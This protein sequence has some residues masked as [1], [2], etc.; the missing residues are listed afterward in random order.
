[1]DWAPESPDGARGDNCGH[2]A[3]IS[4]PGVRRGKRFRYPA[5]IMDIRP[6]VN[7]LFGA[8]AARMNGVVLSDALMMPADNG[9][10]IL[11]AG[12]KNL[13][14]MAR[15]LAV[16]S[17]AGSGQRP[18]YNGIIRIES[19]TSVFPPGPGATPD[20]AMTFC[21]PAHSGHL[22]SPRTCDGTST[23]LSME[24]STSFSC[25][26]SKTVCTRVTTLPSPS[27]MVKP[28]RL[29]MWEANAASRAYYHCPRG[30]CLAPSSTHG[31]DECRWKRH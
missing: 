6:T 5:T 14:P 2:P 17:A 7:S 3:V 18:A 13:E 24:T 22:P 21:W 29:S 28:T 25:L 31:A 9:P 10:H 30:R 27:L 26:Q 8:S 19:S 16:Q 4:G 23:S 11:D 15:A 20:T 12:R 1:M